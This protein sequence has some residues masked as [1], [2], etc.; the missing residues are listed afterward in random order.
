MMECPYCSKI[1][2]PVDGGECEECHRETWF[3]EMNID[4][5]HQDARERRNS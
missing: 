3:V 5:E 2:L 4:E 1:A